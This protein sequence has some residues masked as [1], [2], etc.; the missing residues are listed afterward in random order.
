MA[1]VFPGETITVEGTLRG[2]QV[3]DLVAVDCPVHPDRTITLEL[4]QVTNVGDGTGM[5][6]KVQSG[7]P[8]V[9]KY[10]LGMALP[11]G[12]AGIVKTSCCPLHQGMPI[13]EM[14][15]HPI[16]ELYAGEFRAV[17]P[18]AAGANTCE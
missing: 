18:A 1:T 11:V 7:F 8:G 17:D 9:L 14:W 15:P 13:L 4:Q 10:W 5:M 16:L 3:V 6:L 12:R 2:G